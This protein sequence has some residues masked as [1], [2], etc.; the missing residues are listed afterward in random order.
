MLSTYILLYP[1]SPLKATELSYFYFPFLLSFFHK[2]NKTGLTR[3][4]SS[5]FVLLQ[6]KY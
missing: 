3:L 6:P 5:A 1:N 2:L 4:E